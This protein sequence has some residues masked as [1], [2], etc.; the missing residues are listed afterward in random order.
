M[1]PSLA[2]QIQSM[3]ISLAFEAFPSSGFSL[4][5][6][7]GLHPGFCSRCSLSPQCPF[8]PSYEIQ[9]SNSGHSSRPRCSSSMKSS[10]TPSAGHDI[11]LF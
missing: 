2:P 5:F 3:P 11:S 9:C 1:I 7:L 8:L 4:C 6:S 10:L